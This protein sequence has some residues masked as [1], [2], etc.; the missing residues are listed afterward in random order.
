MTNWYWHPEA[1]EFLA[2]S[3]CYVDL[4]HISR[5]PSAFVRESLAT[6][7]PDCRGAESVRGNARTKWYSSKLNDV[8]GPMSCQVYFKNHILNRRASAR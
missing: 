2:C 8:P 6:S 1:L 4:I 5:F 7:V 3:R